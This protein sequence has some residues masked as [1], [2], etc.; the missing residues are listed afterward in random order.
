MAG[1]S[2]S[3]IV[4]PLDLGCVPDRAVS[5]AVLVQSERSCFLTFVALRPGPDGLEHDAGFALIEFEG[6][7]VTQFGS[8]NDE[9]FRGHPLFA[10][11]EAQGDTWTGSHEILHSSW[12][13]RCAAQ[14]HTAFPWLEEGWPGA[15]HFLIAFHDSTFECIADG[16]RVEVIDAPYPTIFARIA[17]RINAE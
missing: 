14:N 13:R 1:G 2:E 8:P 5:G 17:E 11:A 10:K 9:G 3:D 7:A 12:I 16:L 4:I 6:C 15:R